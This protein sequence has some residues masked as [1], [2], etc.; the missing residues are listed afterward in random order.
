MVHQI[1]KSDGYLSLVFFLN[2]GQKNQR[3]GSETLCDRRYIAPTPR[4]SA[5]GPY[6]RVWPT[7]LTLY[8]FNFPIGLLPP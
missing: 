7:R 8:L 6:F 4:Q 5:G 2:V 3:A 1:E